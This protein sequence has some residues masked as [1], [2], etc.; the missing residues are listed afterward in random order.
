MV[1][2]LKLTALVALSGLLYAGPTLAQDSTDID[3]QKPFTDCYKETKK[4]KPDAMVCAHARGFYDALTQS[5][6]RIEDK[7]EAA[8]DVVAVDLFLVKEK[9]LPKNTSRNQLIDL[10]HSDATDV[11][12]NCGNQPDEVMSDGTNF[13]IKKYMDKIITKYTRKGQPL[14]PDSGVKS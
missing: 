10:V 8:L 4:P 1:K 14:D 5:Y 13:N 6:E 9:T 3:L 11:K 12:K 7:C 2:H